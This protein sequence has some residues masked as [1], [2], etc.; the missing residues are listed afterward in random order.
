MLQ[1]VALTINDSE[2]IENFHEKVFAYICLAYQ[3]AESAYKKAS[4]LGYK[5]LIKKNPRKDTSFIWDKSGRLKKRY[6]I[7]M[8]DLKSTVLK[9]KNSK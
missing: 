1:H 6:G 2:E 3:K 7:E 8:E 9:M 5:T 4:D